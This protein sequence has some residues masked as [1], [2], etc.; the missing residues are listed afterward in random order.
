MIALDIHVFPAPRSPFNMTTSPI[1]RMIMIAIM[2]MVMIKMIMIM[3][4]MI[5]RITLPVSNTEANFPPNMPICSTV[6]HIFTKVAEEEGDGR[7]GD[8]GTEENKQVFVIL[9]DILS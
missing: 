3:I 6:S 5:V 4:M 7:D 9:F 1:M 8:D 2:M